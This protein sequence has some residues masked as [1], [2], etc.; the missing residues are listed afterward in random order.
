MKRV[1][2]AVTSANN[3]GVAKHV[4]DL[5]YY[6]NNMSNSG[7]EADIVLGSHNPNE[8]LEFYYKSAKNVFFIDNLKREAGLFDFKAFFEVNKFIR[9]NK[10][11][12][13]MI[14]IHAPKAGFFFR[15]V[16]KINNIPNIYTNHIVVYRQFRSIFNTSYRLLDKLAGKCCDKVIVVTDSAKKTLIEDKTLPSH[17]VETI[18]NTM[19]SFD[20]K[21]EPGKNRSK[22]DIAC[23]DL[24]FV[25]IMRLEHPKDPWNLIKAFENYIKEN[26]R[27]KL[28]L[29]GNGPEES[30]IRKYVNENNLENNI[31]IKGYTKDVEL[32]LSI[33]DAFVLLT[34]KEG[35][36]I[37]I[38]E[39]MK[40][41]LPIVASEVDGIP[42]QIEHSFNGYLI[43]DNS[44]ISEV[45]NSFKSLEDSNKRKLMGQ[46]S[47]I[48]LQKKF[49]LDNTYGKLLYLY[50][51]L[52]K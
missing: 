5:A 1:L 12:Y 16:C 10:T 4:A 40:Y 51:E 26:R 33:A 7:W 30:E 37:A 34:Y 27:A 36:P 24:V 8:M 9:K 39:A 38:L 11:K 29:L 2:L 44:N 31:F 50:D 48:V 45:V 18:Y 46:N 15:I 14:H 13:D 6:I 19:L 49:F 28:F 47:F 52:K 43:K 41:K 32:Y 25:S 35:L 17:K 42:E 23:N 3:G 20:T 22:M 21:Y